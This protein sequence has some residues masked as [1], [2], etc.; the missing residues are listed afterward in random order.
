MLGA[1]VCL[2]L[3]ASPDAEEAKKALRIAWASQYEWKEDDVANATFDFEWD[4]Q[5][6]GTRP[7]DARK[8]LARGSFVIVDGKIERVH[9][10]GAHRDRADE[11]RQEL[12]W[13]VE[14]FH[15][16]PFEE[17]FKDFEISGPEKVAGDRVLVRA[18]TMGFLLKND[19]I[20]GYERNFGSKE[21][22]FQVRID[23]KTG[24]VGEGYATVEE[25]YAYDRNTRRNSQTIK[26]EVGKAGAIPVPT[27]Y[28]REHAQGGMRTTVVVKL[29]NPRLNAEHP[30]AIDPALRDAVK[31]AWE[32]RYRVP[33]GTRIDAE[34]E[35]DPDSTLTRARWT[36]GVKGEMQ[37]LRGELEIILDDKPAMRGNWRQRILDRAKEH[38]REAVDLVLE[39]SFDDEFK[40]CGF[41]RGENGS[42]TLLGHATVL[43]LRLDNELISAV[44]EERFGRDGWTELSYKKAKDGRFLLDE[45]ERRIEK[46]RFRAKIKY[47]WKGGFHVP[48]R[49]ETF[50]STG[51]DDEPDP[52]AIG[53]LGYDLSRVKVK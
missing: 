22:P 30:V 43:A 50:V 39:R 20:A 9:V 38:L 42:I 3:A 29:T 21:D 51:F 41:E 27:S 6:A 26:L 35:R 2:L 49:Y 34:W 12:A 8:R 15:R 10:E 52:D 14:R 53:V 7:Q 45:F 33:A 40:G 44:R 24:D 17:H 13:V 18:G 46:K 19:R 48:K 37:L 47:S 25:H 36:R 1:F 11:I 32:R 4:Y 16:K 31:A 28:R 5:R 23:V